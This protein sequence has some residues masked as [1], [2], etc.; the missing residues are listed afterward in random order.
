MGTSRARRS[1]LRAETV[2][3]FVFVHG[4]LGFSTIGPRGRLQYF[5]G[6]MEHLEH[7]PNVLD[8]QAKVYVADLDPVDTIPSRAIQLRDFIQDRVL[9][10]R[11]G[12][13]KHQKVNIIAH[14][15]G[16]LDARYMVANLALDR[17]DRGPMTQHVASLTTIGTPHLGTPFADAMVRLPLGQSV[18]HW[19][20]FYSVNIGAFEQLTA[21]FLVD[22]GFN[23]RMPDRRGVRYFSYAGEV[24]PLRVFPPMIP[25]AE[26]IWRSGAEGG[27]DGD[28]GVRNDG[29]VP[30]TSATF[31]YGPVPGSGAQVLPIDH[32]TQIGHGYA[33][34][35][36][37]PQSD[38]DHL[39]F[40]AELANALGRKGLYFAKDASIVEPRLAVEPVVVE[41]DAAVPPPTGQ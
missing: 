21:A 31:R 9:F 28:G 29:L 39:A 30:V 2:Y 25:S 40:Y 12:R 23:D 3:P 22:Q 38:F 34:L 13:E 16:G 20:S 26:I 17:G 24:H 41:P 19:A 36:I 37:G 8:G 18:I 15:M 27:G 33:H 32:A 4:L 14:S 11:D 6:V 7:N 1:W 35:R 10:D 5:R